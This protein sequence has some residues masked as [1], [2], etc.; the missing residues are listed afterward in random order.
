MRTASRA[1]RTCLTLAGLTLA[2]LQANAADI[3]TKVVDYGTLALPYSTNYGNTFTPSSGLAL[4]DVFHDEYAFSIANG[5]FSSITA[6]FNVANVLQ[7]SGLQV[8]LYAGA[9]WQ[10]ATPA[11]LSAADLAQQ[12]NNT[13]ANGTGSNSVLT[14][15]PMTLGAGNYVLEIQ[16]S[17]TGTAGGSYAGVFNVTPV[18]E[19]WGGGLALAGLAGLALI[20]RRRIS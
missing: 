16:G 9:P 17:V 20:K 15:N 2:C 5:S 8:N 7:I 19:P 4:G 13:L 18:P 14:I 12:A 1:L 6:T 3:V 11:T 10:G